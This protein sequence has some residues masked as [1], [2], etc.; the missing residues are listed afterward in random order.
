MT[1]RHR[2]LIVDDDPTNIRILE[3]IL[4]E[5]YCLKIAKGGEEC[6]ELAQIFGPS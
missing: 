3:E 1:Q 6:L 4:A 2:I 5:D